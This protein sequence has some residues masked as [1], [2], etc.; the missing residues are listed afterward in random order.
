[1]VDPSEVLDRAIANGVGKGV[2]LSFPNPPEARH[3]RMR[4]TSTCAAAA[5]RSMQE[6]DPSDPAWG[7]HPW[8]GV[9]FITQGERRLWVGVLADPEMEEGVLTP[10]K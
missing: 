1:M 6:L 2:L 4:L 8:Q 3:Y 9:S 7:K 5:N 10:K